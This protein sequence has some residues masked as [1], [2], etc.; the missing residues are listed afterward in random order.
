MV[1][2]RLKVEFS[3]I[4][5]RDEETRNQMRMLHEDVISRFAL[6]QEHRGR[7]ILSGHGRVTDGQVDAR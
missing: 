6:L 2:Q 7:R 1:S 5:E 3:A 4:R